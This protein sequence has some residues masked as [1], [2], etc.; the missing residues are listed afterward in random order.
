MPS[1][2]QR[3]LRERAI[4]QVLVDR[5]IET[6]RSEWNGTPWRTSHAKA[7]RVDLVDLA[8]TGLAEGG[9]AAG[10]PF[11]PGKRYMGYYSGPHWR[12]LD[13]D[14]ARLWEQGVSV[15]L[16]LVAAPS[17]ARG[18]D[19]RR[20][21]FEANVQIT[22]AEHLGRGIYEGLWVGENSEIPNT[23]GLRDDAVAALKET[24]GGTEFAPLA[25]S[26]VDDLDLSLDDFTQRVNADLVG[27]VVNIASR[28]AG[29]INK[30][31]AGRLAD[32]CSEPG[33][34][35]D[36]VAAGE[37]IAR[38]YEQREFS[39]ALRKIMALADLANQYIDE[40][41]PWVVAKQAGQDAQ[42]HA[43]CSMGI[44]TPRSPRA[45]MITSEASMISSTLNGL[46]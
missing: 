30:R 22:F 40:K 31:F 41:A 38:D 17:V 10:M 46:P 16:L 29:F 3:G 8:G 25:G 33:L 27:K 4:A 43:I 11:L 5:L 15:L 1:A 9:G 37:A 34:Y 28:C 7:L 13:T 12:D 23:R 19:E 6:D 14:A 32:S 2:W 44:S 18:E 26:G 36:F 20:Q 42:L 21:V 45:T 39:H 35:A 24:S